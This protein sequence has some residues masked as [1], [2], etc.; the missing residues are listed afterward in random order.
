[1]E[2]NYEINWSSIKNDTETL[3]ITLTGSLYVLTSNKVGWRL[4]KARVYL[5][6]LHVHTYNYIR[7]V[8]T[9]ALLKFK[10]NCRTFKSEPQ[11]C[12][13]TRKGL[14]HFRWPF[15]DIASSP[16]RDGKSTVCQRI[17]G[18]RTKLFR[19]LPDSWTFGTSKKRT[20]DISLSIIICEFEVKNR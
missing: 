10:S 12:M 11:W 16:I 9:I 3:S 17:L 4:A 14:H 5:I 8:V 1:M 15:P 2:L 20:V 19:V 13:S 6:F 18:L 7:I